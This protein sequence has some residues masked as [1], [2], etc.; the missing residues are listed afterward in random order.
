[1]GA[2]QGDE[3]SSS[4][5]QTH[6]DICVRSEDLR[7]DKLNEMF[8][9]QATSGFENGDCYISKQKIDGKIETIERI[10]DFGVWHLNSNC[11]IISNNLDDHARW[12]LQKLRLAKNTAKNLYNDPDY[13]V[14]LTVWYVGPAGFGMDAQMLS[15]LTSLCKE[16]SV[17][18][19]E[20]EEVE[21]N[22][23]SYR[24]SN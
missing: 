19:W 7:V 8:G 10:R 21:T 22:E 18:C 20:T 6:I 4:V 9:I 16:I 23:Q 15:E 13:F 14:K 1:M 2:V 11:E 17:T 24:Q 3:L 12:L 5:V